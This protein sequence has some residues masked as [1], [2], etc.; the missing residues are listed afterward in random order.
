MTPH[1]LLS[2]TVQYSTVQ[3]TH[4][5]PHPLLSWPGNMVAVEVMNMHFQPVL[6]CSGFVKKTQA[7]NEVSWGGNNYSLEIDVICFLPN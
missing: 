5:T 3:E 2:S 6:V 7:G 1:L 4:V